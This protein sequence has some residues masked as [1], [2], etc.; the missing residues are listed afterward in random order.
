LRVKDVSSNRIVGWLHQWPDEVPPGVDALNSAIVPPLRPGRL[1][2]P[3]HRP[4][5]L[6]FDCRKCVRAARSPAAQHGIL[7]RPAAEERP[8]SCPSSTCQEPRIAIAT[9]VERTHNRGHIDATLAHTGAA[10]GRLL[11]VRPPRFAF[12]LRRP[13]KLSPFGLRHRGDWAPTARSSRTRLL[14]SPPDPTSTCATS[15][16]AHA[17]RTA[18]NCRLVEHPSEGWRCEVR[19]SACTVGHGLGARIL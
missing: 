18:G 9:W 5:D 15:P 17:S 11:Q 8:R 13:S 6:T 3:S 7:L 19:R 12:D 16:W 4:A 1:L 2:R 10:T 14:W